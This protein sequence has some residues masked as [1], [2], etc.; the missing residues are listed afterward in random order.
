MKKLV[1]I[2]PGESSAGS[3]K[4][5][6]ETDKSLEGEII[7]LN[8]NL[9]LGPILNL[10]TKK[11]I[12]QRHKWWKNVT[13]NTIEYKWHKK[14][15]DE[16]A[17]FDLIRKTVK[18]NVKIIFWSGREAFE[19]L[20]WMRFAWE[21]RNSSTDKIFVMDYPHPKIANWKGNLFPFKS[22]A[23][24]MPEHIPMLKKHFRKAKKSELKEA[25]TDWEKISNSDSAIRIV[26]SR[27]KIKEIPENSYNPRILTSKAK[28]KYL[29]E[30]YFDKN[31]ILRCTNEFQKAARVV[32]ETMTDIDFMVGDLYLNHRLKECVRQG[33]LEFKGELKL[34]RDYQVKLK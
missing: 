6:F 25:A 31:L 19:R 23:L 9:S 12:V 18:R 33:K 21:L 34:L 13:E 24:L 7:F 15:W 29:P 14:D 26:S 3:L 16:N 2:V 8:D 32:G 5:S 1:H 4:R 20:T 27:T 30:D 10:E 22:I 17:K 28:I 11:G